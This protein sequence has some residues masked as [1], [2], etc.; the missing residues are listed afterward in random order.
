MRT[1]ADGSCV[2]CADPDD[3]HGVPHGVATGDG[4]RR[5]DLLREA[6]KAER[7]EWGGDSTGIWA[8]TARIHLAVA[9]WLDKAA[10][11]WEVWGEHDRD[12]THP[13]NVAL[14]ILE[15]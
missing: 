15:R 14:A 13:L 3:H 5:V 4:R 8:K 11:E 7:E 6:A 2:V 9:D 10:T 1:R 12:L